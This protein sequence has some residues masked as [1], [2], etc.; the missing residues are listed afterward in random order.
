[1]HLV[2]RRQFTIRHPEFVDMP[3]GENTVSVHQEDGTVAVVDPA[4]VVELEIKSNIVGTGK[5]PKS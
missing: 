1:M 2:D 5:R 4:L 3:A